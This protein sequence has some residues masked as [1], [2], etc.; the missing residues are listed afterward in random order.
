MRISLNM[1]HN[2]RFTVGIQIIIVVIFVG[3]VNRKF[4]HFS[5][6][7]WAFDVFYL[8]RIVWDNSLNSTYNVLVGRG[9]QYMHV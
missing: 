6:N 7:Y 4:G 9:T 2:H 8:M 1:H 3:V 5:Q